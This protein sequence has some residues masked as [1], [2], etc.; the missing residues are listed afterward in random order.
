MNL[1]FVIVSFKS[2][3]LI[4]QQIQS[5]ENNHQIIVVENSLDKNLK[6]KLEKLYSNV[7]VII[8]ES[9]LGYGKA[10]NLGIKQSKNNFL[11][12]EVSRF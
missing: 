9:N 1:S 3:H 10:L 11:E 6:E 4:E 7:E 5:I 12:D 2:F 8:P